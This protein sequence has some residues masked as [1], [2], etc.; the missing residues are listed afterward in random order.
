MGTEPSHFKGANLPVE[1]VSWDDAVAFCDKLSA[2]EGV[3]K[4][5]YRLPTEAEWEYAARAG[6]PGARYGDVGEVAWYDGNAGGQTHDV[7]TKKANAWGLHDMLGNVW[8]WTGDWYG[9]YADGVQVDP[10]G[11]G[12]GSDRVIRGGSWSFDAQYARAAYR[13]GGDPSSRYDS[14]GFRPTRSLT[15]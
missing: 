14:L 12:A 8:E 6:A 3:A 7:G 2:V 11:P 5:T 9:S 10:V 15:K 13:N 1:K 4:G